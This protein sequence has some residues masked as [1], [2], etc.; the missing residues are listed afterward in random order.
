MKPL[1]PQAHLVGLP[2][3]PFSPVEL[4]ARLRA[5]GHD[6]FVE[7]GTRR[8]LLRSKKGRL[9]RVVGGDVRHPSLIEV[10]R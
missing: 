6:A 8:V 7:E 5:H 4:A 3:P 2:P 1:P 9:Y 10:V